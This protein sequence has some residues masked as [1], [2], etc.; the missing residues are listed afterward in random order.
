MNSNT[1]NKDIL[2]RSKAIIVDVDGT[3]TTATTSFFVNWNNLDEAM[4][5]YAHCEPNLGLIQL[6]RTVRIPVLI[7]TARPEIFRQVTSRW[8]SH[9]GVIFQ[10]L[11][12]RDSNNF[13][14]RSADVKEKNLARIKINYHPILAIDDDPKIVDLYLSFDLSV[15]KP[16]HPP[17]ELK[18]SITT[19]IQE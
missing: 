11:Y 2:N 17:V 16:I 9:H 14:E 15:L 18:M 4:R 7:S 8:L 12:M 19:Q 10:G 5:I 6:L 13:L 1:E 3:L